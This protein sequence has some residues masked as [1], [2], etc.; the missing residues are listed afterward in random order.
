[1]EI[2]ADP[3]KDMVTRAWKLPKSKFA[4]LKNRI[5]TFGFS[6]KYQTWNGHHSQPHAKFGVTR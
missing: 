4:H 3:L 5:S 2:R 1:M 6:R